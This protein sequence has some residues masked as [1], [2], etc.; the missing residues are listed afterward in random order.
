[1]P[2]RYWWILITYILCQVSAVLI[3]TPLFDFIPAEQ[4]EGAVIF[5][6]FILALVIILLLLL[7]E[8]HLNM[9]GNRTSLGETIH[10]SILGI[11]LVFIAQIVSSMVD[12]ALFGSPDESE[13][14]KEIMEMV[15][16][17]P[18]VILAVV[19][20]GPI[21]EEIIFRKILFGSIFGACKKRFSRVLSFWAAALPT[22]FLFAFLHGDGHLIVYGSIGFICAY[23]YMKTNRIIVPMIAHGS[24]NS[25]SVIVFLMGPIEQSTT[26]I[27]G[28]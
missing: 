14:A 12:I 7:P 3:Y 16:V 26:F 22:S 21:L 15:E 18:Y 13:H 23:L 11:F 17:S 9:G 4:R 1:M 20:V 28:F 19:L 10:W 8:R 5:S 25:I 27:G 6:S 2:K 24:L